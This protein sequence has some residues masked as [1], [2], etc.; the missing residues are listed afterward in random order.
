MGRGRKRRI[1]GWE[2]GIEEWEIDQKR[3]REKDWKRTEE[4]EEYSIR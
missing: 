2:E 1:E 3:R 4:E